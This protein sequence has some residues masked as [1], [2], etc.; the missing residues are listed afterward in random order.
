MLSAE[1]NSELII[2][3]RSEIMNCFTEKEIEKLKTQPLIE[4]PSEAEIRQR[5]QVLQKVSEI[6]KNAFLNATN[7]NSGPQS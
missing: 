6:K 3:P 4:F 7:T 5:I 2:I 1:R